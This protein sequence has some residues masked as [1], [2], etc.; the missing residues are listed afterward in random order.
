MALQINVTMYRLNNRD[1]SPA[2]NRPIPVAGALVEYSVDDMVPYIKSLV[3]WPDPGGSKGYSTAYVAESVASITAQATSGGGSSL[4]EVTVDDSASPVTLD[5]ANGQDGFF[6]GSPN[7]GG[8]RTIQLV[9]AGSALQFT[10]FF[11][12]TGLFALTLP[13]NFILNDA[14]WNNSTKV[15]T[16]LDTGNYK[17]VG[18][19]NGTSW[20]VDIVGGTYQ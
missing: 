17:M 8:A 11:N 16:P 19:Y 6:V 13:S 14:R 9:N 10:F 12:L 3:R 1:L 18:N 4:T 2:A 7:I 15:W 20:Y 5:L